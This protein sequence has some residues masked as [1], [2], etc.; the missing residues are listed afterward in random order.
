[1]TYSPIWLRPYQTAQDGSWCITDGTPHIQFDIG[2]DGELAKCLADAFNSHAALLS[3]LDAAKGCAYQLERAYKY[4]GFD[5]DF[6]M[7]KVLTETKE[8]ITEADRVLK[9]SK[10][11]DTHV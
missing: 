4:G 5:D 7:H 3:V 10:G 1:M 8:A 6:K 2:G 9:V 11:G